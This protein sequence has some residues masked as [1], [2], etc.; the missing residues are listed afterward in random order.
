M[1]LVILILT[2][3]FSSC[4]AISASKSEQIVNCK[5]LDIKVGGIISWKKRDRKTKQ[6]KTFT[7]YSELGSKWDS[8]DNFYEKIIIKS[9]HDINSVIIF[10][11]KEEIGRY[12]VQKNNGYEVLN[13]SFI[14]EVTKKTKPFLLKFNIKLK[15]KKSCIH[16]VQT[17]RA[18]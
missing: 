9:D 2:L 11:N 5:S 16:N 13:F 1:K 3:F 8:N 6:V 12:K 10:K 14:E 17:K 4:S 15:N 7:N 18:E